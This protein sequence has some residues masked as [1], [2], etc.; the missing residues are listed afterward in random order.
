MEF[1]HSS[2]NDRIVC[3]VF[4]RSVLHGYKLDWGANIVFNFFAMISG[5]PQ[6]SRYPA[7]AKCT[8]ISLRNVMSFL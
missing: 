3:A 8:K 5:F 2:Q 1:F 6:K 7:R 4:V